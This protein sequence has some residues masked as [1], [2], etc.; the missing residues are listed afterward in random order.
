MLDILAD[1]KNTGVIEGQ[2]LV[3]GKPKDRYF[4]RFMGYVEQF[5]TYKLLIFC[6][7]YM[8]SSTFRFSYFL[9]AWRVMMSTLSFWGEI[10]VSQVKN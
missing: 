10:K 3:N 8:N 9:K 5:V 1:K 4:N 7:V 6:L 2:I